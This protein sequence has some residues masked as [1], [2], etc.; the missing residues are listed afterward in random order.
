ME[1]CRLENI[2]KDYKMGETVTPLKNLSLTVNEG[3]FICV[4]GPSGIGK[5]TL[6]LQTCRMLAEEGHKVLY[7]SGEES[8]TQIKM[9]ADRIGTFKQNMLFF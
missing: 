4:E 8:Q 6:L 2:R 1:I 9:R 5:S 7:I 3:D